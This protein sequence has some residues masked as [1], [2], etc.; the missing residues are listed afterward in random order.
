MRI[1]SSTVAM[2]SQASILEKHTKEET[3][4]IWVG[5][6]RQNTGGDML[7]VGRYDD[8]YGD[9]LELTE[10]GKTHLEKNPSIKG[11]ESDKIIIFEIDEREKQKMLILQKML[12]ALTKKK[13]RFYIPEKLEFKKAGTP[14]ELR[15]Q[16]S[17]AEQRQGWGIEYNYRESYYECE[18]MSFASEGIIRTE[19]GREIK[20]SVQLNLS[21]E[22]ASQINISMRAG[23]AKID[24]LVINLN[25]EGPGLQ[26]EKFLF[27][28]DC[29]GKTEQISFLTPGSGFLAIDLNNDG[30]I[31]NGGELF[32]PTTGNGFGEL[33][34][35]D[36][37]GNNWIDENDPIFRNLRIWIKEPEG[38]DRL[39]ALWEKGIGAI[40]VG[41]IDTFFNIKDN[42]NNLHGQ[43]R[44]TGI[45]LTEAGS[46]GIISHINFVV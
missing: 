31:N 19:D 40:Y 27:D 28:L 36:I 5:K 29:D 45:F 41:N 46:P 35:E 32:G 22:F 37:D 21:R 42:K 39:F 7:A 23:D 20:F 6:E 34:R 25:G 16:A 30:I 3:L 43:V 24:P 4:K 33:S 44:K 15:H 11:A 8:M 10:E 17:L 13:L 12:E 9:A 1:T 18:K 38:H 2:S 26:E 14:Q